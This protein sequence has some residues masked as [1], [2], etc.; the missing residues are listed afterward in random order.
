VELTRRVLPLAL[1]LEN[2]HMMGGRLGLSAAHTTA[3][4]ALLGEACARV[5]RRVREGKGGAP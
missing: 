1:L 5:A 4:I 3:D 2:V